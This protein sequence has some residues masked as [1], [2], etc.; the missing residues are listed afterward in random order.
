MD[1]FGKK[2]TK[3]KEVS[4]DGKRVTITKSVSKDLGNGTT[5]T[6]D[7]TVDRRRVGS[8]LA[9]GNII[10]EK[11]EDKR[12][13]EKSVTISKS[14]DAVG[15]KANKLSKFYS[16][17]A[18]KTAPAQGPEGPQGIK[19]KAAAPAAQRQRA[20]MDWD[21]P[22]HER[23]DIKAKLQEIK[24]EPRGIKAKAAEYGKNAASEL[25]KKKQM[26]Y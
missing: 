14:K 23:Q 3:T 25:F 7:K 21:I 20:K 8:V 18:M 5:M 4:A 9:G 13:V 22:K 16:E 24:A 6:K 17:L 1:L 11:P 2:K 15:D 12:K 10:A 26:G 19:A